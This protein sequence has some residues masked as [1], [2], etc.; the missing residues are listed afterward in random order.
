MQTTT[1]SLT[2]V[3]SIVVT[4]SS[5]TAALAATTQT[6]QFAATVTGNTTNFNVTWSVDG[7]VGGTAATGTISTS[8]LYTPPSTGG[9]H[10]VTATSVANS[11][12]SASAS[13]AVTDL[14]AVF[15]HHNDLSRDGVNSQEYALTPSNVGTATFGK[16]F[17]CATATTA[18]AQAGQGAVFAQTLWVP[19]LSTNGGIHNVIFVAT[20]HD[21]VFAF[22]AD[23]NPCVT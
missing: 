2:V 10:T 15:T 7:T 11:S 9:R 23:A 22:D 6:Q 20:Q 18:E 14:A 19:G 5:S 12:Y 3:G 1:I 16:L 21:T 8:G 4:I 17:S 13:A